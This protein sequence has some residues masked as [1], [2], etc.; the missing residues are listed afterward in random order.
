MLPRRGA[1]LE[2]IRCAWL[3]KFTQACT[4]TRNTGPG[5]RAS[6]GAWIAKASAVAGEESALTTPP[7]PGRVAGL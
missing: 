7:L 1:G 4:I 5:H 6:A 2:E 3:Y